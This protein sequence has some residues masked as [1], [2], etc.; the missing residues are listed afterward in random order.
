MVYICTF[1]VYLSNGNG[2]YDALNLVA[3]ASWV[4]LKAGIHPHISDRQ[5]IEGI[6]MYRQSI[7]LPADRDW[8]D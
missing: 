6:H 1:I 3:P 4:F 8:L 2:K 7:D 5:M